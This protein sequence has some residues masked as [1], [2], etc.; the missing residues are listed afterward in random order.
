MAKQQIEKSNLSSLFS[1]VAELLPPVA[2]PVGHLTQRNGH[3]LGGDRVGVDLSGR[4]KLILLAGSGSTGKTTIARYLGE[5]ALLREDGSAP[6]LLSLDDS[7]SLC[8]YFQE[9]AVASPPTGMDSKSWFEQ[10]LSALERS[11]RSAIA[12]FGGG[13]R[14]LIDLALELPGLHTVLQARGITPVLLYFLSTRVEDL[15]LAAALEALDFRPEA[16]AVVLNCGRARNPVTDFEQIRRQPEY[17]ALMERGAME[18]WL[19]RHHAAVAVENRR[20]GFV[21]ANDALN[22]FDKLRNQ[23]WLELQTAALAPIA[24]WLP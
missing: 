14:V 21:A 5:Q 9:N 13:D 23:H 17:R 12:D 8:G 16:T 15:S 22:G 4:Q 10:V 11:G 20:L 6:A 18:V 19:P 1:T 24:S 7:R 2:L 3:A